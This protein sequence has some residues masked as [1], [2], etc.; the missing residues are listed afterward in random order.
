MPEE[1]STGSTV[2]LNLLLDIDGTLAITDRLYLLAFQDLMR[3][4]GYTDVDEA[5]FEKHVAGKVDVD[6]FRALL[7]ADSTTEML[8][9]TSRKKDALFVQKAATEGAAIVPGLREV[10]QMARRCGWRCI[11]VTNAQRGGG[12]AVLDMLRREL[13]DDVAGVIEDLVVGSECARAKPHPDPYLEGIRRLGAAPEHCIVFE[14]SR[15]GVRAGVAAKVAAVVGIRTSLSD[16]VLCAAGATATVADWSELS[17][18]R[19]RELV[20]R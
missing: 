20:A 8:E 16:D 4:F 3:P 9:A 11:A 5:W 10:L 17:E 1:S 15:T 12:Q 13:G 14:D 7:P 6:V 19:L 2:P 18:A